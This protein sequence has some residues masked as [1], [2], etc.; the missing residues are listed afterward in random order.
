MAHAGVRTYD[1]EAPVYKLPVAQE[2]NALKVEH[3]DDVIK[4]YLDK[5]LDDMWAEVQ[6]QL[7]DI[8]AEKE[9][10][11]D[12]DTNET[13]NVG[14]K[15]ISIKEDI[16]KM[17]TQNHFILTNK[18]KKAAEYEHKINKEVVYL[19]PNKLVTI[20]IHPET[21]KNHFEIPDEPSHSTALR[22]FPKAI[23]NGKTP[24]NFGYSF[25]FKKDEEL[26]EFLGKL[27][28]V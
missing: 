16:H 23:K 20:V 6:Q 1:F 12:N 8:R 27:S 28:K 26:N 10:L 15:T 4:P 21:A 18:T 5:K 11:H 22:R 2:A 25:K 7:D 24:T 19:L 13:T 17:F 9:K 14:V 3:M